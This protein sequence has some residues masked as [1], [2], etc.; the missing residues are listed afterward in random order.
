MKARQFIEDLDLKGRR[1]LIRVDFN[2]PLD[3][4]QKITD[5]ARIAAALPSIRRIIESGGKCILMSHLGRP[6]GQRVES[7]SLKPAAEELSLL[8]RKTLVW[9]LTPSAVKLRKWSRRW[10]KENF[11]SL[12]I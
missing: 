8:L 4:N 10:K 7:M 2:V 9:L 12:R 11:C 1:V 6:K 5:N 3:E